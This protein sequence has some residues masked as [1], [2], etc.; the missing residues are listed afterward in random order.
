MTNDLIS[1]KTAQILIEKKCVEFSLKKK[2]KLTS[3]KLSMVYCDCRKII[4]Y[5]KERNILIN[6]AVRKIRDDKSL[7]DLS[8]ISFLS[9]SKIVGHK[10]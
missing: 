6:F 2:F 1:R 9:S 10:G 3:G 8:N 7:K 4:S 5:P